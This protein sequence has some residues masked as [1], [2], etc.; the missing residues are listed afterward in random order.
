MKCFLIVIILVLSLFIV[1]CA[2]TK[3]TGHSYW[4][5]VWEDVDLD[6]SGYISKEE[7]R[8]AYPTRGMQY[9]SSVDL[10]GDGKISKEEYDALVS[11]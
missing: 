1:N 4:T 6:N 8:D 9:F 11:S 2:S 5:K 10:D 3:T 7:F